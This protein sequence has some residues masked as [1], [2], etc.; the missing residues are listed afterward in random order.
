MENVIILNELDTLQYL[1]KNKT[2]ISRFG[3]GEFSLIF[4]KDIHFQNYNEELSNKL[5]NILINGSNNKCL[6]GIPPIYKFKCY[7]DKT[8]KFWINI[9]NKKFIKN[10]NDIINKDCTYG[11][12][13]ISRIECFTYD[14]IK[15]GYIDN[16][17]TLF[18]STK[19]I[20][21]V[22]D[23]IRLIINNLEFKQKLNI[24]DFIIIP[25]KNAF[26]EYEN[27]INNIKKYGNKYTFCICAGPTASII[28]YELS[29]DDYLIY[30]LGHFFYL[31]NQT[32]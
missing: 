3:D 12:S 4:G 6:V 14:V 8:M 20:F 7:D 27:I 10:I 2:S 30:D 13:F 22:N 23:N 11:S 28:S 32:N 31:L 26:A 18:S 29:K 15:S 9:K 5:K 19:N 1:I 25:E 21:I 24:I 16:F 17:I